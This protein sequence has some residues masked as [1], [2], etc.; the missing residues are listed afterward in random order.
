MYDPDVVR[1]GEGGQR[2]RHDLRNAL[3]VEW[4]LLLHD[5]EKIVG[6]DELHHQIEELF[7]L[8]EI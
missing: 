8:T 5:G 7:V 6:L 4:P 2:L 3:I 1:F